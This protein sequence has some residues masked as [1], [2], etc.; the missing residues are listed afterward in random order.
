MRSSCNARAL[1]SNGRA[2]ASHAGGRGIDTPSVKSL[3]Q[4]SCLLSHTDV[5]SYTPEIDMA[6][7]FFPYSGHSVSA[8][9]WVSAVGLLA[10]DRQTCDI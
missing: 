1:R 9:V 7:V 8:Y 10:K 4:L 3:P 5:V 6:D 2:P